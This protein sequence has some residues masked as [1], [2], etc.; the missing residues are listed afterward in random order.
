MTGA[1]LKALREKAGVERKDLARGLRIS[2]SCVANWE[3]DRFPIPDS[4]QEAIHAVLSDGG[5]KRDE[6]EENRPATVLRPPVDDYPPLSV[7]KEPAIAKSSSP[8]PDGPFHVTICGKIDL[9]P[10][11]LRALSDMVLKAAHEIGLAMGPM[12][13][14]ERLRRESAA[15]DRKE[16]DSYRQRTRNILER[17]DFP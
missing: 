9:G 6:R 12:D 16:A 10:E 3:Q 17:G 14:M 8:S 5:L 2:Y 15:R 13:P 1:E 4:R 7:R 11:T